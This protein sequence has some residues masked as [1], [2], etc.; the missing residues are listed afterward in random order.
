MNVLSA[1]A[2]GERCLELGFVLPDY[3]SG[4]LNRVLAGIVPTLVANPKAKQI[5]LLVDGFGYEQ[6]LEYKAHTPFLRK[7]LS[8]ET[9]IR[10]GFP[11]TTVTSLASLTTGLPAGCTGLVGY[12]TRHQVA[13]RAVNFIQWEEL[14]APRQVQQQQTIFEQLSAAGVNNCVVSRRDYQFSNL[15]AAVLRGG[16]FAGADTASELI[17]TTDSI[18]RKNR[19]AYVYWSQLDSRGHHYGVGSSQWVSALEEVDALVRAL[20]DNLKPNQELIVT[21]DHGMINADLGNPFDLASVPHLSNQIAVV[22]GEPRCTQIFLHDVFSD[23]D[24]AAQPKVAKFSLDLQ[25]A[26]GD[27]GLV[28]PK[29]QAIEL[30]LFG[31]RVETHV[32]PTIGDVLVL[33][34][35]NSIVVDSGRQN[36]AMRS[37]VGVHGSLTSAE[38]RIP[39]LVFRG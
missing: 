35:G 11:S 6:L 3:S 36:E 31:D 16:N 38:V 7:H 17:E 18:M 25:E 8:P 21:A 10:C 30:G 2:L 27:Q 32:L 12:S 24:A 26:L 39:R 20:V 13:Q 28:I 23:S 9:E 14:P 5:V 29:Q 34:T 19:F 4:G 22:A 15:T 1:Q 33:A 37:L